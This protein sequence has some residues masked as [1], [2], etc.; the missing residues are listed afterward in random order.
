MS[1]PLFSRLS[2]PA[3]GALL[4]ALGMV[5][6]SPDGTLMHMVT[7]SPAVDVL[8]WRSIGVGGALLIG[9]ALLYRRRFPAM[10]WSIGGLGLGAGLLGACSNSLFVVALTRTSVAHTLFFLAT[11]PFWS[12]AFARLFLKEPVGWRTWGAIGVAL[13]GVGVILADSLHGGSLGD[14]SFVGDMAA[15]GAAVCYALNLVCLRHAGD[16]DMTASLMVAGLLSAF[17]CVPFLSPALPTTHDLGLLLV[18]G[19]LV[20]PLSLTLYMAGARYARAADVSLL[21]L[22]ETVLGPFWAWLVLGELPS[23]PVLAGGLCIVAA[24]AGNTLWSLRRSA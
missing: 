9:L 12:A 20:L 15:L 24:V 21:A 22:I 10:V 4:S 14:G 1:F 18:L 5:V 13:L 11:L 3:R 19:F 6:I 23:A 2:L 7:E 16:R 8:F 17:A